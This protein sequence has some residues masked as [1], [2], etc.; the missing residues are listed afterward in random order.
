MK[1]QILNRWI[2]GHDCNQQVSI[3]FL[4]NES[5]KESVDGETEEDQRN[6]RFLNFGFGADSSSSS[7]SGS[8]GGS[9]NFIFDIIRVSIR[10]RK[11]AFII[12]IIITVI[13]SSLGGSKDK[14]IRKYIHKRNNKKHSTNKPGRGQ[15]FLYCPGW[16]WGP[17]SLLYNGY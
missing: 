4:G 16:P 14:T 8:G 3:S 13:E 15:D 6:K 5:H 1:P 7:S 9:G 11:T 12:I 17:P 10:L 2:W